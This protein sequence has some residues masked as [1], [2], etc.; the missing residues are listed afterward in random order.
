MAPSPSIPR[1]AF[2]MA[3]S[4]ASFLTMS[5]AGRATT[6]ELNVFQVLELRSVIGLFILLP[7]VM[8]SGGFAA[9]RTKRP[10]AHIARNVVHFVGQ[11]AWLYALTLIPLAVLI[12]IEFTTP[13]WTA[14]LAVGF[15]GERLSRP[16]L[17]AIV[18]GLIGVVIIVRP[19]V[20]SVDPGHIVVLG[21]AVCFGISV[22]LVKSLTRTDSVVSIIFWMLVIQSVLGLIPALYEWRNPPLELWPWILLIAFTG[23]SS[24]FCMA[25]ALAYADATVISPMDFLRVPLSALIGWL[26]YHEQIDAF[27]AGGALLILLGNLLNLQKKASKPAEVAAS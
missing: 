7:L 15:L 16:R 6:A 2:W 13:I 17:A 25:R 24:H 21:A 22:V 1:A 18:L 14:I 20:G 8:I 12:S 10:L 11:A 5:V 19:G 26:L 27:T 9:M 23:M 4:I 3:L